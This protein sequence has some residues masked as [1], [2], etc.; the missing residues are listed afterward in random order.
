MLNKKT[1]LQYL[2]GEK[3]DFILLAA[4]YIDACHKKGRSQQISDVPT[5]T[6]HT[7]F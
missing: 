2:L 3:Q 7:E 6:H 5:H 4:K 1:Q